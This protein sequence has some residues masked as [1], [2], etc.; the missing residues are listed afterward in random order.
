M[1]VFI[2]RQEISEYIR[3]GLEIAIVLVDVLHDIAFSKNFHSLNY[4][5]L[6]CPFYGIN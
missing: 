1:R 5:L 2:G 3:M 6:M 4:S